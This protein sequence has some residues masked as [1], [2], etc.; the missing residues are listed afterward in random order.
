M[1]SPS[2]QA[3]VDAQFTSR[4]SPAVPGVRTKVKAS[5]ERATP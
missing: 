4:L 1:K 5:S 2:G 3:F